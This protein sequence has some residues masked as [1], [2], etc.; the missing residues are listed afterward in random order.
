MG[1]AGQTYC[2]FTSFFSMSNSVITV[3]TYFGLDE[4][5]REFEFFNHGPHNAK[6]T[7]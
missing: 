4:N 3:E 7:I 5:D 2:N 6:K 1:Y